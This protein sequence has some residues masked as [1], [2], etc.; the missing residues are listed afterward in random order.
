ME[1]Q[2]TEWFTP[3]SGGMVK[4]YREINENRWEVRKVEEFMTGQKIKVGR[5][6]KFSSKYQVGLSDQPARTLAE[7]SADEFLKTKCITQLITKDEFE[8]AWKAAKY[9]W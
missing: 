1:Y 9:A 3:L 7:I 5:L 6:R 8:A 2:F 4:S